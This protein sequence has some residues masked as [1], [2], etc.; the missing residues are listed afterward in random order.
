MMY[1]SNV[2]LNLSLQYPKPLTHDI[3]FSVNKYF[4]YSWKIRSGDI[5]SETYA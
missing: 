5:T 3:D 4:E 2:F 1:L